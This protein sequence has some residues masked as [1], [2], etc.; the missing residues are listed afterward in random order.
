MVRALQINGFPNYY[1]TDAGE[2]YSRNYHQTGRIKKLA[3]SNPVFAYS[4]IVV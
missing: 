3:I 4:G 1:I 2:V